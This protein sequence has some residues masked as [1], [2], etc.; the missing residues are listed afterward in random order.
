MAGVAYKRWRDC[1]PNS[2]AENHDIVITAFKNSWAKW[3]QLIYQ[4]QQ[5]TVKAALQG[6]FFHFMGSPSM[7]IA[8]YWLDVEPSVVSPPT[9][10]R[11]QTLPFG[12]LSWENFERLCYRLAHAEGDVEDARIYGTSGQAQEGI[13]LYV[14][15]ISGDYATWQCKRYRK[16]TATNLKSFVTIF[17]EGEWA[18]RSKVFRLAVAE[19]MNKTSLANEIERQRARCAKQNIIFESLDADRLSLLLKE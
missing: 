5:T 9:K 15:R 18:K 3:I 4:S 17:L 1:G 13:D 7:E 19:S 12:D 16:I 6:A 14:R 11:K 8:S 2:F 10:T